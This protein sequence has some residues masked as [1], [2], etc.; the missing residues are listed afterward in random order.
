MLDE[1]F[2]LGSFVTMSDSLQKI[3]R[4]EL[5]DKIWAAPIVKLGKELRSTNGWPV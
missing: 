5:Y 1:F 2:H 4:Q 3:S